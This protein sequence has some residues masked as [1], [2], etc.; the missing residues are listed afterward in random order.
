LTP[1]RNRGYAEAMIVS[2]R[3]LPLVKRIPLTISRGTSATTDNIVVTV[4]HDGIVGCGE[5][6]PNSVTGDTAQTTLAAVGRWAARL[7]PLEPWQRQEI[8]QAIAGDPA[9]PEGI[10]GL[11]GTAAVSALETACWDWLG[12][13]AGMPVWQLLGLDRSRIVETSVTV[14][15]NPPARAA[16]VARDWIERTGSRCL[17]IKLGSPDGIDH[18]RAMYSAV[19]DAAGEGVRLRVDANGGWNGDDAR[20]MI[21]FLADHG[22]DYVEQPIAPGNEEVLKSLRPSPIPIFLDESIHQASDIPR[23]APWI[24]GVN[25]KL[26]KTGGIDEALRVVHTARACGLMTMLGCMG[27]SSLAIAAGAHVSP[28]F[29]YLDLDS[30]LNLIADPWTGLGWVDGKVVPGD[31]PGL[32]VEPC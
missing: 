19:R 21:A 12:K 9:A 16:D 30:H 2:T 18:D 3:A 20:T 1:K 8:L 15:I 23:F 22:C 4:E 14:G 32:G 27:E 31:A 25:T 13:R 26:M 5:M 28:L 10:G 17:K 11:G 7:R 29:D 24:D 6:A